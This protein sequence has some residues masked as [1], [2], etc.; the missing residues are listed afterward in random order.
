MW[1]VCDHPWMMNESTGPATPHAA[2]TRLLRASDDRLLSGVAGGIGARLGVDPML[3]RIGFVTLAFA[4]G[5]GVLIYAVLWMICPVAPDSHDNATRT[6]STQQAVALAVILLGV[7]VALRGIG[8]WFGDAVVFP[9]VLAATGSAIVWVRGDDQLRARW[10]MRAGRRAAGAAEAA[11]HPPAS[12]TR[13]LA[14]AA[15]VAVAM[16]GFLA[17]N[18]ALAALRELGLAA[19]AAL[20]GS[21]LLF[22]PWLYRLFQQLGAERRERIR[23]E[24]R[25]E[26]AAHLH[27]SVLQTLALIRRSSNDPQRVASLA[28]IQ[29]RQLRGW[30]YQAAQDGAEASLDA[31]VR[32]IADEI[33]ADHAVEVRAVVVGDAPPSE[34]VRALLGAV[35]EACVNAAKHAGSDRIDVFIEVDDDTVRAFVR[36]RGVGFDPATVADDRYGLRNSIIGRMRRHAGR[37]EITS[38]S[39]EGTE[40]ELSIP[41]RTSTSEEVSS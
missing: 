8:L 3:V 17:A 27:D 11:T 23:Q 24:E 16:V 20:A 21:A 29:E 1:P 5:F 39:G 14:G 33:E 7:L 38:A 2:K 10:S 26:F 41:W 25:A 37:A 19:L 13:L 40:V 31:A 6:A 4:G 36:D 32:A 22:G 12:V 34:A 35:R 9:I 30:L 18:D 28:R 15:L